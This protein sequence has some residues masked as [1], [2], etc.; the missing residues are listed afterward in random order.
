MEQEKIIPN[1]VIQIQKDK[2][3]MIY[4]I[5][6]SQLQIYFILLFIFIFLLCIGYCI[7]LH[8]K[9]YPLSQ[10]PLRNPLSLSP[11]SCFYEGV[12]PPTHLQPPTSLKQAEPDL[13][14]VFTRVEPASLDHSIVQPLPLLL[15]AGSQPSYSGDYTWSPAA[16]LQG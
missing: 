14:F 1:E 3:H 9:C 12:P 13:D 11:S 5:R 4:L 10:F 6:V 15:P 16:G 8:F 2:H 7:Y